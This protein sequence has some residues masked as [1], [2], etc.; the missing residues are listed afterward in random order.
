ML[1]GIGQVFFDQVVDD[2][3]IRFGNL[4]LSRIRDFEINLGNG[5]KSANQVEIR[6]SPEETLPRY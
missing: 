3:S 2:A 1:C 4:A 6:I 5:T